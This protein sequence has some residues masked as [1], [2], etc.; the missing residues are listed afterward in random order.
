MGKIRSKV[1]IDKTVQGAI[2]KRIILHWAVFFLLSGLSVFTIEYFLGRSQ[3]SFAELI[4]VVTT[5]YA[6]FFLIMLAILPSFIYDTMKISNRFAGPILRLRTSL[7]LLADNGHAA[8]I[9]FREKD[10]WSEL[11]AD[12]N[13]VVQRVGQPKSE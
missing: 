13:R 3:L 1:F 11:S 4:G 6:F 2:V 7:K 9:K 8:E 5:K 12:F 10:F